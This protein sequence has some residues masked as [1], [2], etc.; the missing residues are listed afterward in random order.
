VPATER[1][2]DARKIVVYGATGAGKS[3]LAEE[4]GRLVG[5]PATSVDDICWSPG[6][7]P[8]PPDEQIA[9]FDALTSTDAWVLDS[10]YGSWRHL[11]HERADLVVALD[12]ARLTS[13]ARL[14]RRTVTRIV[15]HREICN[16]NYES[17]RTIFARDSLVMWHV[18]SFRRTRAEMRAWEAAASGPPVVRL[19]R[20][21]HAR[22]FVRAET[23][24]RQTAGE[25]PS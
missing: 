11:A 9:H 7:V 18:T 10:A 23:A 5:V 12:Y 4:L 19:R 15:D 2:G 8:M 20:P 16:G 17:W 13:L 6:W 3:V 24:L 1:I 22:A 14:L 21:R 25:P